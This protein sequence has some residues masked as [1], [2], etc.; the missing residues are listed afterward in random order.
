[1]QNCDKG[2]G[3]GLKTSVQYLM[4]NGRAQVKAETQS[5]E[6]LELAAGLEGKVVS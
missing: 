6:I 3:L 4:G 1:M 5:T 2:E